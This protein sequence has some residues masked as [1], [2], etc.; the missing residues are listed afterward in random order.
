[1]K[2]TIIGTGAYSL[3][4]AL[5][6]SKR[7]NNTITLWTEDQNKM[8][9]FSATHQIKSIFKDIVFPNNISITD[10]NFNMVIGIP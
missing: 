9:E 8:I 5:M 10:Y 4:I 1:M 2:I 7:E 3:G 6:L